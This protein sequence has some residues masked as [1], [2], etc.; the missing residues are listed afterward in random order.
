MLS[1]N[2]KN[3]QTATSVETL[4]K[5]VHTLGI[6]MSALFRDYDMPQGDCQT[7]KKKTKRWRSSAGA[8]NA[9]ITYHLLSL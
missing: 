6:S 7:G 1:R 5:L 4:G 2:R 9:A 8:A 3:A